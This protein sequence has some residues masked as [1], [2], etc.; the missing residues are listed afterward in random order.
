MSDKSDVFAVELQQIWRAAYVSL[1][2]VADVF[3]Q[4]TGTLDEAGRLEKD[5]IVNDRKSYEDIPHA[6]PGESFFAVTPRMVDARTMGRLYEPWN[7][8]RESLQEAMAQTAQNLYDAAEAL[9][10]ITE[11]YRA[12]D[13]AAAGE[14]DKYQAEHIS[15][16]NFV[17][18]AYP[19]VPII[20]PHDYPPEPEKPSWW[21]R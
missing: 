15:D 10:Q 5:A 4:A 13:D 6:A 19:S 11:H 2:L 18:P 3:A 14:L 16:P 20:H 12:T 17:Y 1:P 21:K 7:R 8:V 9:R